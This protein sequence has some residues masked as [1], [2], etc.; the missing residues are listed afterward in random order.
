MKAVVFYEHGGVDKLKYTDVPEPEISPAEVLVRVRACAINH[1]DIWVRQGMPGVRIPLPHIL[2]CEAAG[3][4]SRVGTQVKDINVGDRVL[5]VPGICC[6]RCHY[7]LSGWDSLCNEYKIM[8]YQVHGGY[9]E[10]VKA[11]WE[12][13]IHI[14]DRLSFEEW[15]S[16]PLVFLTAWHMLVSRANL[17]V[18]ETVLVHAAGSGVGSAAIQ[19]AKLIGARVIATAGS[20]KKLDKAKELGADDVIDYTKEDFPKVV[21]QLT[22]Q[23][24]ADVV[25]EHI[26]PET[27]QKSLASLS[28]GGRLVTCGA[29]SGPT[30]EVD[31]RFLFVK[32]LSIFGSYMGSRKEL[33]DVLKLVEEGKLK[34]VIDTTFPLKDAVKAQQRMLD[35]KQFGKIV[36]SA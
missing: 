13:I 14:S 7:C 15:A 28:K 25:F 24:G 1:L 8:G 2:G 12:N 36:L 6:G 27:W 32:Q 33:L 22:N 34:P 17:K 4:V 23:S 26:G 16:V 31:L 18:G 10:F 5:V 30:V 9:A 19:V 21:K 20:A 3:E 11:P 29:T 35:R